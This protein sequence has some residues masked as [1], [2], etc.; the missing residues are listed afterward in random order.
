MLGGSVRQ[1]PGQD[2]EPMSLPTVTEC[3]NPT[4]IIIIINKSSILTT[5]N[6]VTLF[7]R[8]AVD[9]RRFIVKLKKVTVMIDTELEFLIKKCLVI[10]FL[11]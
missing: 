1:K 8:T 9:S 6:Y 3:W 5:A 7:I 2:A 11:I 4:W 10:M